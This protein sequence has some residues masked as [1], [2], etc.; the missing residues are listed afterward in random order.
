MA[1]GCGGDDEGDGGSGEAPTSLTVTLD[2][3]GSGGKEPQTAELTCPGSDACDALEGITK[4]DFAQVPPTT[5]CTEIFGGPDTLTIEGELD[6]EQVQG[7]FSRSNGCEI[8]RFG[9]FLPLL[10]ALFP[11]Y[12]PG[13][14]LGPQ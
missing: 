10:Q 2:A 1:S 13:S 14:S 7:S 9:T 3:D 4:S 5:A 11:D 8:E 6:G 12:K